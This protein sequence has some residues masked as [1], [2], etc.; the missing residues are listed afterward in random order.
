MYLKERFKDGGEQIN[1]HLNLYYLKLE[2]D[3]YSRPF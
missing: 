3:T 1:K 2:I